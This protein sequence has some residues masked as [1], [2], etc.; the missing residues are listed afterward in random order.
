MKISKTKKGFTLIELMVAI[1]IIGIL[2]AVVIVSVSGSRNKAKSAAALQ[3]AKSVMPAAIDCN[4]RGQALNG[5]ASSTEGGNYICNGSSF[6]WPT[7]NTPSTSGW[8]W[9]G[10]N[11][12]ANNLNSWYYYPYHPDTATY[13][14]CPVTYTGWTNRVGTNSTLPGTCVV[15][16]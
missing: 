16:Q 11:G 1:A 14:M 8:Q 7:L 12:S 3:I 9:W 15:Q 4:L 13:I 6:T 2:A 10:R 5:W